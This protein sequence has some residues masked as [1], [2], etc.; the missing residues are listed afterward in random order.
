MAEQ[1]KPTLFV[2]EATGLR[3]NVSFLDAISMNVAWQTIGT[4]IPIIGFYTTLFPSI[5][6]VNLIYGTII[7]FLFVIPHMVIYTIMQRRMP[8]TGGDYVWMS[9]Q[10]GS[11]LGSTIGLMGACLN[12]LAFIAIVILSAVFSVGSVGISLGYQNMLG[13]ALPSNISGSDPMSQCILGSLIFAALIAINIFTPKFASKLLTV[14]TVVGMVGIAV[15]IVVL[16]GAGRQGVAGYI[17]SLGIANTTYNSVASSYPGGTFDL[18]NTLMLMPFF[19]LFLFPWFNMSTIAGSEL[20]G[21]NAL[22]WSVPIGGIS[23]FV[24]TLASFA[25]LYYAAGFQFTN[26]ALANST[27]VFDYGLNFWTLAMGVASNVALAWFL[28]AVWIMWN[29][30]V[31][32]VTIMAV[33]RYMLSLSFDRFLPSRLAY[34]SPRF[35]SPVVALVVELV[36]AIPLVLATVLYYGPLSALADTAV[37]PMIFFA[38][39]GIS[40]ILYG[41][42]KE[43]GIIKTTLV[44]AGTL[45][46]LVF[47]YI[48]YQFFALASIYGG[49]ILSYS[50]V[51]G[52]FIAGVIIYIASRQYLKTKGLDISMIYK[53][54]PPE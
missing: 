31:L 39:V 22:R 54:I 30:A 3:K 10:L 5:A 26:A 27:L 47:A 43:K 17:N 35:G 18:N 24:L 19:F 46:A 12:F 29:I 38:C 14:L 32:I 40:A 45:S 21:K 25:T 15:A 4:T 20:K 50:F 13:L 36:V 53:E 28:G 8:R 42:R 34:V 44:V 51:A 48:S 23:V 9:R 6:G 49:N 2:R 7:G 37:A 11:F 52:S 33:A 1:A 41:I 16:L